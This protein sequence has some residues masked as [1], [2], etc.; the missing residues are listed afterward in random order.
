MRLPR[1]TLT[2]LAADLALVLLA[3]WSAFWLR[4]NFDIP[5]EFLGIA[6]Q[7]APWS[8]VAYGVGLVM[9]RVYR[10]VWSYIGLA[11]LRQLA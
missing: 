3:G 10:Q 4:F 6:L 7:A 5:D 11:E 1:N 2:F 9:A 8:V